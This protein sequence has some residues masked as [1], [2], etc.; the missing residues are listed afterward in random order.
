[1]VDIFWGVENLAGQIAEV[2]PNSIAEELEL[3][4]GDR[5][6]KINGKP[7]ADLIDYRYYCAGT[8]TRGRKGGWGNLA[9]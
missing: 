5:L 4:A 8:G 2:L 6:L 7:L 1:M 3:A 9:L